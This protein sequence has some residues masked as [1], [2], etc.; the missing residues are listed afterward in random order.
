MKSP[1]VLALSLL[2]LC[3][4]NGTVC[5]NDCTGHGTCDTS[6]RKCN[7]F[8][9]WGASDDVSLYKAPDC[10]LRKFIH[11]H[12]GLCTYIIRKPHTFFHDWGG[13]YAGTCPSGAAWVD[14]ATSANTAHAIAECSN[15]GLCSRVDGT[16]KCYPGFT[17]DACQRCKCDYR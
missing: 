16:C 3:V 5:Y 10:S 7:C 13:G 11:L 4:V 17:G 12:R 8:I 9:G 15:A 14:L 6:T 2:S 1:L